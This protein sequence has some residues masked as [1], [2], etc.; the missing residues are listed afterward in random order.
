MDG[1]YVLLSFCIQYYQNN[2]IKSD[3]VAIGFNT[4]DNL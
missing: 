3:I 2:I 4:E 1:E